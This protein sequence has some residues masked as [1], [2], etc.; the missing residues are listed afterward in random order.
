MNVE[1]IRQLLM[2]QGFDISEISDIDIMNMVQDNSGKANLGSTMGSVGGTTSGN[3]VGYDV[4]GSVANQSPAN[5][6]MT[7]MNKI[8][9]NRVTLGN[10]NIKQKADE[11]AKQKEYENSFTGKYGDAI[12]LGGQVVS[13][14]L[15]VYNA[16][17]AHKMNEKTM[18][19]IDS[20]INDRT[21]RLREFKQDQK[22]KRNA[23]NT[24]A[25]AFG[26]SQ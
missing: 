12:K 23:R 8:L 13:T 6:T 24:L 17:Q 16:V 9:D 14:G 1:Q 22:D 25:R 5:G 10:M 3:S 21:V 19:N 18:Q 2:S 26:G 7:N 4:A 11:I 15:A 20:N